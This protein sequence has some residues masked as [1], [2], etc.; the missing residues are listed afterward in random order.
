MI[1]PGIRRLFRL[2]LGRADAVEREMNE[3]IEAHIAQRAAQLEQQGMSADQARAEAVRRFGSVEDARRALGRAAQRRE[4]RFR[5]G[6]WLDEL[7]QDVRYAWRSVV[8][9]PGLAAVVIGVIA[10]GVG[11]NA[12]MYGVIDRLLLHGPEHVRQ[13]DRLVRMDV[14]SSVP[15][16][17]TSTSS[18]LWYAAYTA[19]RD[20]SRALQQVGAYAEGVDRV[21]GSGEG[22][23]RVK[24]ADATWNFFPLLG[25]HA[26]VGRFF[27]EAEDRPGAAQRVVVL[28]NGLWRHRF[29]ADP[30]VVGRMVA[31][32]GFR[33]TVV[34]V[35]PQGFTGA[36]LQRVELWM[37]MSL[38]GANITDTWQTTWYVTWLHVVGR[39]RPGA[40]AARASAEATTIFQRVYDG[41]QRELRTA[42]LTA[43][44][45]YYDDVG[46]P[47]ME[48]AISRW[49]AGVSFVVLLVACANVANLLL[50]RALRR[51]R[52]VALR[53]ALGVSRAR[54][55]R[56]FLAE[57]LLLSVLGGAAALVV[58]PV[59]SGA[60]RATLLPNV[61]WVHATV[62]VGVLAVTAGLALLVGVATGLVPAL[63]AGRRGRLGSL[64][65]LHVGARGGGE[66]S[67]HTRG[68]LAAVQAAF[69]VMLII[70][71]GLFIRSFHRARTLDLGVEPQRVVVMQAQWLRREGALKPTDVTQ[72]KQTQSAFYE[73]A[74]E[75][76]RAM[77]DVE[78]A[79]LVIGTPFRNIFGSEFRVSG[80]DSIPKLP[81]G[82]PYMQAVSWGYF[83][84][85]GL[86]LLRGRTFQPADHAGSE[87]VA[88]IN[89]T[90][91][92]TLWPSRAALGECIRIGSGEDVP[93]ARI[94]GV[95][96]DAHRSAL[97][98]L[99]AMQVYIPFGQE[100]GMAG[101]MLL[102]RP[103]GMPTSG[104]LQRLRQTAQAVDPSVLWVSVQVMQDRLDPQLRP[105][106]L[107]AIL[108]GAFGGLALLIAAVGLYSLIAYTVSS[109]THELGVRM[110]LGA[111]AADVLAL[112]LRHG[113]GLAVAGL[114]LGVL[115]AAV[116]APH[117]QGLLFQTSPRDPLVYGAAVAV[118]FLSALLASVIPARRATRVD[119]ATVL[120]SD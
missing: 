84:T 75:R 14:T 113:L 54:L 74:L 57:S 107:G 92:R 55:V 83:S 59:A 102:V 108:V 58:V 68:V 48:V 63:Q 99:P 2:R 73:P 4:R 77:R 97:R 25:V 118:L 44:P 101:T 20:G 22:A 18:Y 119:P 93:C 21:V 106:R 38:R 11:A 31:I 10:V 1:R 90:M 19:L 9:A 89:E 32:N 7:R 103:R 117:I 80:W 41:P 15:G 100:R 69:S 70:G 49:L 88:V 6:Q 3:E 13:P 115:A 66:R 72:I 86:R 39:L 112:V 45:L 8:R 12:A 30:H 120:R 33:Y 78:A 116:I 95:V 91:A 60:V 37:P 81:G 42:R 109:R 17:G 104:I 46:Q 5:V 36:E 51:Q 50:A 53:L 64:G 76:V 94:V 24:A 43:D 23:E 61:E 110:A 111:R 87:P 67:A 52:E 62:S 16:E 35:A 47:S 71:A 56:L 40:T 82:G 96:E 79:A 27:S 105:W 28:G 98:E 26:A 65:S 29:G 114:A 85:V 34:G